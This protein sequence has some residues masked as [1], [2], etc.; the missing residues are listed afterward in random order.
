MK[1][2]LVYRLE[3]LIE[4]RFIFFLRVYVL[5]QKKVELLSRQSEQISIS[6]IN[7]NDISGGASRIAF[8]LSSEMRKNTELMFY[9]K[10]KKS[11]QGWIRKIE[12]KKSNLF[13]FL[14]KKTAE[15][16]G[17]IEFSGFDAQT[18]INDSFYSKSKFVHLHNLHDEFF[19]PFL[20]NH[21]FRSKKILWTIHDESVYTGHCSC[22]LGCQKWKT[23]CGTCPNLDT[24][25]SVN[26][27]NTNNVYEHK[28]KLIQNLDP[29]FICPSEWV[30]NRLKNIYPKQRIQIIHNGVDTTIFTPINQIDARKKMG[31]PSDKKIILFVAEYSTKNPFKGGDIIRDL[32]ADI[33][34]KDH[35]F[36]TVGEKN[37]FINQNHVGIGYIDDPSYLAILYS[38]AD[39]L[40]YP[41]RA[42]NFPLVVLESMSCGTPVISSDIGGIS[43]IITHNSDGFLIS[44]YMDSHFFKIKLK[45]FFALD[46]NS[47]NLIK[48]ASVETVRDK[49]TKNQMVSKYQ[50][51]YNE[52]NSVS[53]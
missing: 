34:F 16:K 49:F 3:K 1:Q 47:I 5:F 14:L 44:N 8:D 37:N 18:L 43:E 50:E 23:G 10:Y 13:D 11:N 33:E 4:K 21:L 41:T 53:F 7:T 46:F 28:I 6:V 17:W 24:Y 32:I 19:S 22:T 35:L 12:N 15:N 48:I 29:I 38:A 42:D 27:D 2:F 31:F 20:F 51:L 26:Y 30:A 36:V 39:I 9:V 25:P 40:L 45:E 52:L